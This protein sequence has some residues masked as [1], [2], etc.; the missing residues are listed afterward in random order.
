MN[1]LKFLDAKCMACE[2]ANDLESR[3]SSAFALMVFFAV[4]YW[5]GIKI[6]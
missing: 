1:F 5:P 6:F 3:R 4:G 2:V